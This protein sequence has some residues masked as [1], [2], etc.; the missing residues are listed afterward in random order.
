MSQAMKRDLG[1]EVMDSNLP[2]PAVLEVILGRHS[3]GS[4]T[5]PRCKTGTRS[6]PWKLEL[7]P[8]I[9]HAQ[10]TD[11][12]GDG[13]SSLAL[14]LRGLVQQKSETESTSGSTKW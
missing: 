14:K 5:I 12:V 7:S 11:S 10:V 6:L 1:R 3:Y 2:L 8:M 9:Q 4:L 13:A